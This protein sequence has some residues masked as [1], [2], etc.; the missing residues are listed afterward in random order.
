MLPSDLISRLAS[1]PTVGFHGLVVV[2][3]HF[4]FPL[5]LMSWFSRRQRNRQHRRRH[6]LDV[7]LST[8]QRRGARLR[9]LGLT[10]ATAS[11]AFLIL[12][13]CWRGGEWALQRLIFRNAAFAVNEIDIGTDGVIAL[14]QLR[15]W[16]GIELES[17]LFALDLNRIKREFLEYV[18]VIQSAEVERILPHTLRI[19]VIEREPLAQ[20]VFAQPR[21]GGNSGSGHLHA[22]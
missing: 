6:V 9:W 19:R 18:P 5:F 2:P 17:N 8:E 7:K 13:A 11:V 14:E 4:L 10:L 3:F 12:V 21:A 15:R 22:G 20:F 1:E 16:A